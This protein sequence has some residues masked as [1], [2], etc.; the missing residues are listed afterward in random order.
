MAFKTK[1]TKFQLDPSWVYQDPIDFEHKKYTLLAYLQKLDKRFDELKIYP[2]FV[3]LSLHLAN[4]QSLSKENTMLTINKKFSS[5]DDEILFK[6]LI[7]LRPPKLED[8]LQKEIDKTVKYSGQ[9]IYEAFNIAK[10]LWNI[11]HDSISVHIKKNKNRIEDGRGFIY[12]IRKSN[13]TTLIWEYE[14]R[15]D[16]SPNSTNKTYLNFIYS[17]DTLEKSFSQIIDEKSSWNT[18]DFYK[19]IPVFEAK[20]DQEFPMDETFVPMMKR[21]L[22]GYIF[23]VVNFKKMKEFDK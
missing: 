1:K 7:P 22:M 19:D 15:K 11:V 14:I 21:A 9:K 6:E 17:G 4:L 12:Y 13:D 2:D 3:E 5:M 8:H 18:T 16:K 20:C 23:Q 10:S